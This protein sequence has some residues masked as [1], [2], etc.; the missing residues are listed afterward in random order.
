MHDGITFVNLV[1]QIAWTNETARKTVQLHISHKLKMKSDTNICHNGIVVES[2]N[3]KTLVKI[4]SQSACASCYAKGMC[5]LSEVEEKIIE[6]SNKGNKQFNAGEQ[7]T[8]IMKQSQGNKALLLSYLIPF[9][10]VLLTLFVAGSLS[11]SEAAMGLSAL[12]VLAV[13]YLILY[14]FRNQI[15]QSFDFEI[16]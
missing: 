1:F 11:D 9:L 6:V 7:V 3:E 8:V 12:I 10:V 14:S 15:K 4:L 5:N 2:N 16:E 13:Y